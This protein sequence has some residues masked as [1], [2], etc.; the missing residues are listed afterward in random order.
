M[1]S[2]AFDVG[3][4]DAGRGARRAL[5][6]RPRLEHLHARA[7]SREFVRDGA[8]DDAGAD[9]DDGREASPV[10]NMTEKEDS[11]AGRY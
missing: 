10:Q 9:D 1:S 2:V 6:R 11:Y 7:D 4:E 8:A 3:R 5:A